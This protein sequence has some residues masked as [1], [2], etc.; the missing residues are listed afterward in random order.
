MRVRRSAPCG[1][2]DWD[3]TLTALNIF[4]L[5]RCR[6][7]LDGRPQAAVRAQAVGAQRARLEAH[8]LALPERAVVGDVDEDLWPLAVGKERPVMLSG[9]QGGF[10]EVV[11]VKPVGVAVVVDNVRIAF[12]VRGVRL[13]EFTVD[14]PV[15]HGRRV[16]PGCLQDAYKQ[17]MRRT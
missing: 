5:L 1:G 12:G 4:P 9:R 7:V 8:D 13:A 2:V 15:L 6:G 16:S 10:V 17:L 14:L 3:A 11:Y